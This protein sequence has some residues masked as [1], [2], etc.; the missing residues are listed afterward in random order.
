VLDIER[1]QLTEIAEHPWQTDTS[2][3]DWFYNVKDRYKTARQVLETLVDITSNNGNLVLNIPQKP[4]GTLDD[5]CTA[6]LHTMAKWMKAGQGEGI[7]GTRPWT[8]SG[9][10]PSRFRQKDRFDETA[11]GW[12]PDDYR[13]NRKGETL[14]V[15]QMTAA[16]DGTG[17]VRSLATGKAKQVTA[18]R[19]LGA[20]PVEFVQTFSGLNFKLPAPP[21][22]DGPV[23][24]AVDFG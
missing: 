4:D 5:E 15:Y 10:G 24:L 12:T 17:V 22:V 13:F 16:P 18:V 6:L 3:G 9:E 19:A 2:V 21:A 11:V 7:F 8:Q 23:G 20:G 14:F 1:S